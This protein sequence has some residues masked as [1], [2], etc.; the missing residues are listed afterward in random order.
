M[1]RSEPPSLQ[2]VLLAAA[3]LWCRRMTWPTVRDIAS[4][5]AV[6]ASTS[7]R[8]AGSSDGLRELL[9]YSEFET[10]WNLAERG[11]AWS[12]ASDVRNTIEERME[13]LAAIDPA[14]RRLPLIATLAVDRLPIDIL[15]STAF[16]NSLADRRPLSEVA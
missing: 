10:L 6:A 8:V 9:I 5:A 13:R 11:S 4:T 1:V 15:S 12:S 3:T 14:L 16:V 2:R 7:L